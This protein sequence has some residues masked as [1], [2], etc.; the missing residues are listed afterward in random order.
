MISGILAGGIPGFRIEPCYHLCLNRSVSPI[1]W[2][3]SRHGFVALWLFF[4]FVWFLFVVWVCFGVFVLLW[5]FVFRFWFSVF[6]TWNV[7]SLWTMYRSSSSLLLRPLQPRPL[8]KLNN[9]SLL[10][11]SWIAVERPGGSHMALDGKKKVHYTS[12]CRFS[13]M[14]ATRLVSAACSEDFGLHI[15]LWTN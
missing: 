14:A 11:Q 2:N 9:L 5:F 4:C 10:Q 6:E 12:S 7:T 3:L 1:N 8:C 13:A 15:N